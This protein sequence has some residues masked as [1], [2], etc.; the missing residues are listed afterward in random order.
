MEKKLQIIGNGKLNLSVDQIEFDLYLKALKPNYND[1]YKLAEIQLSQLQ[2]DMAKIG[3]AKDALK[4]NSFVIN[5]HYENYRDENNNYQTKLVGYEVNHQL[6]LKYAYDVDMLG[7]I[8][9]IL[10]EC[11]AQPEFNIRFTV[12]DQNQAKLELLKRITKDA[13]AKARV[14]AK[15]NKA[16]LIG[17]AEIDYTYSDN[18]FYSPTVYEHS[19]NAKCLAATGME[20]TAADVQIE[21]SARFV[22]EI[23]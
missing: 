6:T 13:K 11:D 5:Q 7:K 15:E 16:K 2:K 4:T 3:F 1:A 18:N 23:E 21:G 10:T 20:I 14:L 12:K 19:V 17:I 8:I 22:W 9:N